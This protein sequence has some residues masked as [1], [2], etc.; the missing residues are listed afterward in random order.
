MVLQ[1]K[2]RSLGSTITLET[3]SCKKTYRIY[4]VNVQE[5]YLSLISMILKTCP[6][7]SLTLLFVA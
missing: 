3:F 7:L 6:L 4:L 2:S 1:V 5:M